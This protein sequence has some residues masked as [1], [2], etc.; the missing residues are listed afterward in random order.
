MK[1]TIIFFSLA[2][3]MIGPLCP[4]VVTNPDKPLKGEWDFK[5]EKLW[6]IEGYGDEP[7]AMVH[8]FSV[9]DNGDIY[10]FD[11]RHFTFFVLDKNGKLKFSFGRKGE[12]PGEIKFMLSF[13]LV[14]DVLVVS[15]MGKVHYFGLDGK[16]KKS[17]PTS[18]TIGLAPLLFI[19]ENRLVKTRIVPGFTIVSEALEI[20]NLAA[21]TSTYL[22]GEPVPDD[23]KQ[24]DRGVMVMINIGSGE[25]ERKPDF[26]AGKIGDKLLWGKNDTY[27]IK[28]CDFSGKE[29]FTFSVEG[30]KRKKITQKY[31]EQ[32]VSRMTFRTSTRGGPSPDEI[33]KRLIKS[34]PDESTYFS[35]VEAGNNGLIYVYVSDPVREN[36]QEIDIFSSTGKYLYHANIAFPAVERIVANGVVF[37][38]D[39]L[40]LVLEQDSG[41]LSFQKYSIKNPPGS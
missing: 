17:V 2:F 9:H 36:G 35:R 31:K 30:R 1:R 22:E 21:K 25:V 8:K 38:G 14:G 13:F 40:Y 41:D 32:V 19:D 23:K 29:H 11:R 16:F 12:G 20:F 34:I 26:V 15:D 18:S 27:L 6:Q 33:K 5:H 28:A 10:L 37:K 24:S 4:A 39:F 7:L 3:F